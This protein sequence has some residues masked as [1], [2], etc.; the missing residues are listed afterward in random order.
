MIA[1]RF[2]AV[3]E[4]EMFPPVKVIED[5]CLVRIEKVWHARSMDRGSTA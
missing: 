2:L 3:L 5:I 4:R 1:P